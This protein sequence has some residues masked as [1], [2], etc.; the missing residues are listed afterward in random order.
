MKEQ[1]VSMKKVITFAGAFIAFLIGS[2][3]ATGQEVLQYF[4]SYGYLGIAGA[5][6]TLVLL[7]FVGVSFITVGEEQKFEKGSDIYRYYCGNVVGTM[8]DYFSI[9]FIFMSFIVMIA[10]AGA[11]FQQHFGLPVYVGGI[12]MAVLACVTV[13]FGL[14]RIVEVIG[15][16]GPTIVVISIAL[17]L[18]TVFSNLDGFAK[19]NELLP[20]LNLIKASTN[21]FFAAGSYVG[22]CMLWLASFLSSMGATANSKKE[23][24]LGAATGAILFSLAVI[25]VALG[26][27]V[28][29]EDVAGSQIPSLILAGTIH[30]WLA[31]LF[32]MIIVA[33][34]YTTAV[35]LLWSV[36]SRFTEDKS[37]RFRTL[38]V[39][40]AVIGLFVGIYLPFAKLVNIIYVINGYVGIIL[41]FIMFFK[42]IRTRFAPGKL[43]DESV[44]SA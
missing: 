31:T 39:V 36:S 29:I 20:K 34:I 28:R 44:E 40:L 25:I 2:G 15:N 18:I 38:T 9:L 3:F 30:P 42:S 10:G 6:V 13:L 14:N 32:S 24:A 11:T 43:H 1:T 5:V 21:W 26:L 37:P 12:A 19:A 17:G 8:F 7:L 4:S 41:L 27:L 23:A 22:F 16:I 33:G 35:P